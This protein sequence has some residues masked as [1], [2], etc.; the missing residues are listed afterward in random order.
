MLYSTSPS[1]LLQSQRENVAKKKSRNV[2]LEIWEA[3]IPYV[4][5]SEDRAAATLVC[6]SWFQIDK[7]TREHVTVKS[8]YVAKPE[9]L[10]RRFPNL[11]SL[12]IKG[13][14]PEM[15]HHF[16]MGSRDKITP[17]FTEIVKHPKIEAVENP[18]QTWS[19]S[20]L[21]AFLKF[22]VTSNS[23]SPSDT[24]IL[25]TSTTSILGCFTISVNHGV[26]LSLEPIQK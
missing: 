16:W 8:A 23:R 17:W 6:K 19:L 1:F 26:V 7:V 9:R 24:I 15:M 14:S 25:L 21:R 20:T 22:E 5:A 12:K 2:L 18:S 13:M 11:R 3:I 10:F 4:K